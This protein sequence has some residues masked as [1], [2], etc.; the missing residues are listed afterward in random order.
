MNLEV[1]Q[2]EAI[3]NYQAAK[4]HFDK[5]TTEA[6]E[7]LESLGWKWVVKDI[8]D[9]SEDT[10]YQDWLICPEMFAAI[11]LIDWEDETPEIE[12]EPD[13]EIWKESIHYILF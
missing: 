12:D 6:Q 4:Q 3:A 13:Y 9:Y 2:I 8:S 1:D 11:D 5:A 10:R 7:T